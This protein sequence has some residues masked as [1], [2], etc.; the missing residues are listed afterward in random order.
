MTQTHLVRVVARSDTRLVI[1]IMGKVGEHGLYQLALD[2]SVGQPV[3]RVHD[4]GADPGNLVQ[5]FDGWLV[6]VAIWLETPKDRLAVGRGA[7]WQLVP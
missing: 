3:S 1:V 2:R 7:A 4:N 5:C 6:F